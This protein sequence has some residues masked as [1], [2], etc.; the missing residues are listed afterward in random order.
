MSEPTNHQVGQAGEA[1]AAQ[2]LQQSNYRILAKNF[3]AARHEIDLIALDL[4]LDAPELVFIEV[5]TR[6]TASY[7]HPSQAVTRQK[8]NSINQAAQC[9]L[10]RKPQW[11]E[12]SYRFD[13]ITILP[14]N[15]EHFKNVSLE[16]G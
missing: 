1:Q 8:L 7:G 14:A 3:T 12:K 6:K 5:K 13:I 11:L 15:L 9:Y 2:Y 16:L 10:R 4:N